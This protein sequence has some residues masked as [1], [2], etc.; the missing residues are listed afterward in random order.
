MMVSVKNDE[1]SHHPLNMISEM[2]PETF[3]VMQ[4]A[5]AYSEVYDQTGGKKFSCV[6]T[7]SRWTESL[8]KRQQEP[9]PHTAPGDGE[10]P[11]DLPYFRQTSYDTYFRSRDS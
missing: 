10:T 2:F 4:V 8:K 1:F 6:L 7:P 5:R 9:K 3:S 11:Y